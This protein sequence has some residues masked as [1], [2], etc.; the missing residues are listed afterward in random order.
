MKLTE[1]GHKDVLEDYLRE[2][3]RKCAEFDLNGKENE[4]FRQFCDQHDIRPDTTLPLQTFNTAADVASIATMEKSPRFHERQFPEPYQGPL[5]CLMVDDKVEELKGYVAQVPP[6]IETLTKGYHLDYVEYDGADDMRANALRLEKKINAQLKKDGR[7]P[8]VIMLDLNL[9]GSQASGLELGEAFFAEVRRRWPFIPL[10]A[11][12]RYRDVET[13][14]RISRLGANGYIYKP[15]V[16]LLPFLIGL[17]LQK[18]FGPVLDLLGSENWAVAFRQ[19]LS[20]KNMPHI[21]W[22]GD[23]VPI[24]VDHGLSHS[25]NLWSLMNSLYESLGGDQT[26]RKAGLL[27]IMGDGPNAEENLIAFL[28]AIWLH[29]IGHKGDQRYQSPPEVRRFHGAISAG[30]LSTRPDIYLPHLEDVGSGR[31]ARIERIAVFC[32]SHVSNSPMDEAVFAQLLEK[33]KLEPPYELGNIPLVTRAGEG[34]MTFSLPLHVCEDTATGCKYPVVPPEMRSAV[35]LFRFVDAVDMQR[36]R[37]GDLFYLSVKNDGCCREMAHT[38]RSIR[39]AGDE[40]ERE[41]QRLYP[42]C[43]YEL[44]EIHQSIAELNKALEGVLAR[45][46]ALEALRS[47]PRDETGLLD[48]PFVVQGMLK[49][50][51]GQKDHAETLMDRVLIAIPA[52]GQDLSMSLW[53]WRNLVEYMVL[54]FAQQKHFVLHQTFREVSFRPG[55]T[56]ENGLKAISVF[57]VLD[58]PCPPED[59]AKLLYAMEVS[60]ICKYAWKYVQKEWLS[61]GRYL[62]EAGIVCSEVVF[63]IGP[64]AAETLCFPVDG[65]IHGK[66][67]HDGAS[68]YEEVLKSIGF[69]EGSAILGRIRIETTQT[70]SGKETKQS[71][72]PIFNGAEVEIGGDLVEV[73]E[74]SMETAFLKI[75]D[76]LGR[77][78]AGSSPSGIELR[79]TAKRKK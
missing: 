8:L 39:H 34:G 52:H 4:L 38:L 36:N 70:P 76:G 74:K 68:V 23:K 16:A 47:R 11:L 12:T 10:F 32:R 9:T 75:T 53:T 33:R 50:L 55:A 21:L 2:L 14:M 20:W 6:E 69:K 1:K 64:A 73:L 54:L 41:F 77:Q 62:K 26:E 17:F 28:L 56:P 5:T 45:E 44:E 78:G 66:G 65:E 46:Q 25:R 18:E 71:L 48:H 49:W 31:Y 58:R 79:I 30:L 3:S 22:F 43:V 27:H 15:S 24:M 29:D 42:T 60:R 37:V 57:Y 7:N 13:I 59:E 72:E 61:S 19:I 63:D 40:L 67:K 35:S 51:D